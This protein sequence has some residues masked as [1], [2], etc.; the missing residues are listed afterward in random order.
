MKKSASDEIYG[1]KPNVGIYNV[2]INHTLISKQYCI[3]ECFKY[4][5]VMQ[6]I[7]MT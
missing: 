7:L 2:D 3:C 1:E 5:L 4:S 6:I